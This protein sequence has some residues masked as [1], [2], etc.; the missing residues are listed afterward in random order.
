M[1]KKMYI[2]YWGG[3]AE[4]H[5]MDSIEA[6]PDDARYVCTDDNDLSIYEGFDGTVY[7]VKL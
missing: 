4:V 6:V 1:V 7:G 3:S 5:M 2:P